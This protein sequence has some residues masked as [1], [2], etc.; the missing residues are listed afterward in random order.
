MFTAKALAAANIWQVFI[1]FG[2]MGTLLVIGQVMRANIKLFQKV[3]IPPA[4]IAGFLALALGPKGYAILPLSNAFGTYASILIVLVFAATPIGDRPSKE[5]MSGPV[6]GGMFFNIT[7]IAVL[8]YAVGMLVSVYAFS[9][10][11]PDLPKQFGLL[12]AT[13]FYGGHGTAVAVG[14]ALETLGV[15]NMTDLAN[16]FATIGIVGGI[17]LGIIIINW[18]TRRGYTHYVTD[19]QD[20]PVELLTGLV[21][22]EKQ[23]PAGKVTISSISV[24]PMAFH[25][26]LVIIA[27]LGGYYASAAF[28]LWTGKMGYAVAVPEFCMALLVG[29]VVNMVLNRTS[30][31]R[32][33]DR[34]SVS[35]VMGVSTDFLMIAGIGSMNLKVVMNFA[36]P[37][38]VMS[39][40]GFA[41]TWLWFIYVGGKSSFADWFE[42]NM[43]GWGH[44]TGVVAT[45]VLLLRVVDPDL[46]SRGIEDTGISDLFNR[47]IIIGLQ[48]IP[49]IIMSIMV[50]N[51]GHIVTWSIFAL[52]A[53]MWL[54][55][56]KL[57]WWVPSLPL[58][59]YHNGHTVAGKVPP[60]F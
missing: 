40:I 59:K 56:W 49:P 39:V 23:R 50:T 5:A 1:D 16:T 53:V 57:K 36:A 12:M 52:L 9:R 4:L 46:K 18:G 35:R 15:K 6:I 44:A 54:V 41:I 43:I 60:N 7:G 42:R 20:L 2:I 30:A 10:I 58:K 22:E 8:Q 48:V 26:G 33:V 11:W 19:P 55:A 37:I 47:P 45:G 21:P 29:F 28:E 14:N 38:A 32:Y 34:Y 17:I 31:H 25:I 24:D 51:G 3:L 13:G 27:A